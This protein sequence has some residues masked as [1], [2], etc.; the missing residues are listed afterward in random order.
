MYLGSPTPTFVRHVPE[1]PPVPIVMLRCRLVA[2]HPPAPHIHQQT[3]GKERNLAQRHL[4]Q[5]VDVLCSHVKE[6]KRQEN[7]IRTEWRKEAGIPAKLATN[8]QAAEKR[9]KV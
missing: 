3:E 1:C 5:V 4:H 8:I 9:E 2:E 6:R 7:R